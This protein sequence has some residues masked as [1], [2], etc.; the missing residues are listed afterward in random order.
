MI[1]GYRETLEVFV[2][3]FIL[4]IYPSQQVRHHSEDF[5][6]G[7][8]GSGPSQLALALLLDFKATKKEALAWYQS[9][10]QEV[11]TVLPDGDF[12]LPMSKVRD[13]LEVR[14]LFEKEFPEK[15][16]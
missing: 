6:W 4:D 11:I 7:Y 15:E 10:K 13:W 5:C 2:D 16:T 12:E 3:G 8:H 1:V 9:F 14:R